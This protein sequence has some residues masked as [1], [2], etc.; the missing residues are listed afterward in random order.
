MVH[1]K[2][3]AHLQRSVAGGKLDFTIPSGALHSRPDF[4][5]G[6]QTLNY[7]QSTRVRAVVYFCPSHFPWI[8]L[9]F[10][11]EERESK[12]MQQDDNMIS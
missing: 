1:F 10:V 11:Q 9:L 2:D 8:F 3:Y 6:A 7:L 4:P 5:P 12:I